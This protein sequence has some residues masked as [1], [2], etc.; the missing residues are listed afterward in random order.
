VR[1][2]KEVTFSN[3]NSNLSICKKKPDKYVIL[4]L[5]ILTRDINLLVRGF[6]LDDAQ[7]KP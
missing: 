4:G 7:A 2:P 3:Y 1:L 5:Q 6:P